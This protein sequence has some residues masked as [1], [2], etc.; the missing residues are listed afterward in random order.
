M[1]IVRLWIRA[2]TVEFF[3]LTAI[4]PGPFD[5][6]RIC[7]LEMS[8]LVFASGVIVIRPS[9]C[10]NPAIGSASPRV[11][12]VDQQMDVRSKGPTTGCR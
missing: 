7:A 5:F 11:G 8:D 3:G 4:Q 12:G 9:P 10:F 2:Q 1:N 6:R